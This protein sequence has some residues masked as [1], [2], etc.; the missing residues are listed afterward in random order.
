MTEGLTGALSDMIKDPK[1]FL[2][3]YI[4]N[5][6]LS[7]GKE[8]KEP[9]NYCQIT[10][11]PTI[12]Y[13]LTAALTNRICN[14]LLKNSILPE[15]QKGRHGMPKGC[16]NQLLVRKMIMSFARK[17]LRHLYGLDCLQESIWRPPSHLAGHSHGDVLC[18]SSC[19]T[20]H[21]SISERMECWNLAVAYWRAYQ[22][23][24]RDY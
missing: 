21:E 22:N 7:K 1:I 16:R 10:C 3:G 14:H 15:D 6:L 19:K 13:I 11:L 17:H 24:K 12:C 23:R 18:M 9:K 8:T 20:V 2:H 4:R 5:Y